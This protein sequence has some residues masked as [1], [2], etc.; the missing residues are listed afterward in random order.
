LAPTF[1]VETTNLI[2]K[3]VGGYRNGHS[4]IANAACAAAVRAQVTRRKASRKSTVTQ[5]AANATIDDIL[6]TS[7]AD[8]L[9]A[10][11]S[12][13]DDEL[14]PYGRLVRK[15]LAEHATSKMSCAVEGDLSRLRRACESSRWIDVRPEEGGEWC[16][17]LVGRTESFIDIYK[18]PDVYPEQLWTELS[19]YFKRLDE[20]AAVLPGGRYSCA[21]ALWELGLPCL[22]SRSLGQVCHIVQLAMSDRKLLGYLDGTIAPYQ[23]SQ[24]ML[25]DTA[26]ERYV[27][28]TAQQLPLATWS[29]ARACLKEVLDSAVRKGKSEVPLS[30]LKRLFR[31]RFHVELSE[32]ALGYTKISDLLQDLQLRDICYVQLLERGYVVRP[33]A[34]PLSARLHPAARMHRAPIHTK[35]HRETN[36]PDLI[37]SALSQL[38]QGG[39]CRPQLSPLE[40][41]KRDAPKKTPL[42]HF[43]LKLTPATQSAEGCISSVVRNTFIH[44][45]DPA[46]TRQNCCRRSQSV[47]K[48]FGSEWSS[49]E[50]SCLFDF[51]PHPVDDR[52]SVRSGDGSSTDVPMTRSSDGASS[53]DDL[54]QPLSPTLTASPCW[55]PRLNLE[56]TQPGVF[57]L[58]NLQNLDSVFTSHGMGGAFA[59]FDGSMTSFSSHNA[60]A[61]DGMRYLPH[62]QDE[63]FGVYANDVSPSWTATCSPETLQM[64]EEDSASRIPLCLA[65]LL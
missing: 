39:K 63:S 19:Q 17:L 27:H 34:C 64:G 41:P 29:K 21:F 31:S 20:E 24:S 6:L 10:I 35:E 60:Q 42:V 37:S 43:G 4:S 2:G 59:T 49:G 56:T 57:G 26:A 16:A 50:A 33:R 22:T 11:S 30:N 46:S 62:T 18:G 53:N 1:L 5:I 45:V 23:R 47:P 14:R 58:P 25:K 40:L 9:A 61:C 7:E 65:Y 8:V 32:T 13:Y 44:A 54:D 15:R 52:S 55:T 51:T 48:D 28:N 36:T 12:L 38:R 3:M